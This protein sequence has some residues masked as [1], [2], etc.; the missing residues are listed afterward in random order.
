MHWRVEECH[1]GSPRDISHFEKCQTAPGI[2]I[3]RFVEG[4][5]L[6]KGDHETR[7]DKDDID[8]QDQEK[9]NP[10]TRKIFSIEHE[11]PLE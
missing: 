10:F 2:N 8:D 5:N 6:I 11:L 1:K 7:R 3:L 4:I 9:K